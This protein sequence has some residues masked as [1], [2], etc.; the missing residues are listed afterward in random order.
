MLK[1]LLTF[2]PIIFIAG[3]IGYLYAWY[4]CGLKEFFWTLLFLERKNFGEPL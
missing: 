1:Y 3:S 4:R 2:L